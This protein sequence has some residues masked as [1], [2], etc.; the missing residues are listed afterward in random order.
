MTKFDK[1]SNFYFNRKK[2]L[3][4]CHRCG[5]SKFIILDGISSLPLMENME[6]IGSIV[7]GGMNA[8]VLHVACENCGAVTSHLLGALGLMPEIKSND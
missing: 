1:K 6:M 5:N 7:V 2:A 8:P 3:L 4:P